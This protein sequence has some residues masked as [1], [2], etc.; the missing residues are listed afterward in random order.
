M[1]SFPVKKILAAVLICGML[2]AATP[3]ASASTSQRGALISVVP[4]QTLSEEDALKPGTFGPLDAKQAEYGVHAYRI[5]Y[6]T[7]DA[8]GKVTTASGLVA[9]PDNNRRELR[10]V[11]YEHGTRASRDEVASVEKE[12]LDYP[13][14]LLI[15]SAG[16]AAVSPDY[17]GLGLGPG[18]HPYMDEASETTASLDMLRA[19]RTL[20]AQQH[21]KLDEKVFVTGF[22]QGG[23]AAMSLGRALQGG[24]DRYLRLGG[25]APISGPYDVENAEL[26][27]L[28]TKGE[29]SP[30]SGAFYLAY[31]ITSM[32]RL[33]HLYDN[34]SE[35]FRAP[36]DKTVEALFDG[37]HDEEVIFRSMARSPQELLTD[38]Y[39]RRLAHPTGALLDAM[40]ENDDTC[41][42]RPKVPVRL[43][44]AN[45]D[46]DVT[47]TNSLD[48]QQDLRA[49]GANA[50]V[51]NLGDLDHFGSGI[52]GIPLAL[53]WFSRVG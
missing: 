17:L 43:Y 41:S 48:C 25:L 32:N 33:H 3:V 27:G 29:V 23:Q 35:V 21:R 36:Y 39:L 7:I 53:E 5:T 24:A 13:V 4:V 16:Y 26:P 42:W 20:A 9:L 31:W 14:T 10:T 38:D 12:T 18:N 30:E 19:A 28:L 8:H 51:V 6:R 44:A 1:T 50:Q 37:D 52:A 49:R 46:T 45:L 15:A 11:A 47:I 40:R 22:S 34:P 2:L